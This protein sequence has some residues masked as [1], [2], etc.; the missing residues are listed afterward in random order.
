MDWMKTYHEDHESVL[1]LLAKVEGNILDLQAG[2]ATPNT[3]LEFQEFLDIIRNVIIPHFRD[4]EK[5][6]Y[7]NAVN[8]KPDLHEFVQA[9]LNDHEQMYVMFNE[10]G[11]AVEKKNSEKIIS[12][13]G[14]LVHILRHH[15]IK[16]EKHLPELIN[17]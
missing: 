17:T 13:S 4:E 11:D 10:F 5:T 14:K 9:M 16:E 7:K 2:M 12:I 6:V 1:I 15:I 3:Y 8:L